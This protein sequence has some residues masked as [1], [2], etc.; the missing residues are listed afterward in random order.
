MNRLST[1]HLHYMLR[2]SVK[3]GGGER[4]WEDRHMGV[5]RK[6]G[7]WERERVRGGRRK[8]SI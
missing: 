1:V 4:R 6:G 7:M 8:E 5:V 3:E 2:R